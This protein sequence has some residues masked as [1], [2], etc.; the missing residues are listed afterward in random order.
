[1]VHLEGLQKLA[2][3]FVLG[4]LASFDVAVLVHGIGFLEGVKRDFAF[5]GFVHGFEGAQHNVSPIGVQWTPDSLDQ[6]FL[7]HHSRPVLVKHLEDALDFSVGE[8]HAIVFAGLVE[9]HPVD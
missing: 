3:H 9:V 2:E 8:V 6:L 7:R 1:M 4:L 5:V